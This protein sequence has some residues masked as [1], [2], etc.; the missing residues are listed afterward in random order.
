MTNVLKP[1]WVNRVNQ[2]P[3]MSWVKQKQNFKKTAWPGDLDSSIAWTIQAKPDQIAQVKWWECGYKRK[4]SWEKEPWSDHLP[5]AEQYGIDLFP[6]TM[7]AQLLKPTQSS[8]RGG[9]GVR[10]GRRE[11]IKA[12][13]GRRDGTGARSNRRTVVQARSSKSGS[14]MAKSNRIEGAMAGMAQPWSFFLLYLFSSF[15]AWARSDL[16]HL[17]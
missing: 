10:F 1:G 17:I 15:P 4:K 14:T 13:S 9:V 3:I 7:M 12:K 11:G 2:T 8:G 16:Y 6:S 5:S